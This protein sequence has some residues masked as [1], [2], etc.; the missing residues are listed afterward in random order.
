[1]G[2]SSVL[3]GSDAL[4]GVV[5][6]VTRQP[7]FSPSGLEVEG[8]VLGQGSTVNGGWAGHGHVSVK[9]PKWGALTSV[10]RRAFGELRMGTWRAH[11]DSTWGRVPWLVERIEGRDTLVANPDPNVQSLTG[12]TNGTSSSG[13]GPR[14]RGATSM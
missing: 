13:F 12:M 8:K 9:A 3:Y 2:P 4:G 7:G 14:C 5:Q 1:M 11:G 6:F 10:S